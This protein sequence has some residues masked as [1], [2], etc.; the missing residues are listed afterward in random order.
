LAPNSSILAASSS[1]ISLMAFPR[2]SESVVNAL[3]RR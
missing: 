2:L 1:A 3:V